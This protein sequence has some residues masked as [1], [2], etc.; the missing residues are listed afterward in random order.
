MKNYLI[1]LITLI[2]ISCGNSNNKDEIKSTNNNQSLIKEMSSGNYVISCFKNKIASQAIGIEIF[3]KNTL[4]LNADNTGTNDFNLYDDSSCTNLL[5]SGTVMIKNYKTIL[6]SGNAVLEML[7][8]DGNAEMQLWIPY[9]QVDAKYYI[10]LDY[11]DGQSGPY[12]NI[13]IQSEIE[14]FTTS[15]ETEG[16]EVNEI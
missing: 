2:L 5:A 3:T 13:P 10:D 12:L 4:H 1:S 16:V 14:E 11:Q 6:I 8:D 9:T 7:Q 15:P